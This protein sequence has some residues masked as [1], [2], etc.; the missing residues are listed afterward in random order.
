[1]IN[2]RDDWTAITINAPAVG[3]G[4]WDKNTGALTGAA[5]KVDMIAKASGVSA[6]YTQLRNR[7]TKHPYPPGRLSVSEH[8]N[9]GETFRLSEMEGH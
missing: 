8:V 5:Q 2:C 9:T 6:G 1:M 4:S 3:P 7:H